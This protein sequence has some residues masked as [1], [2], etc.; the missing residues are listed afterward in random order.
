MLLPSCRSW[1]SSWTQWCACRGLKAGRIRSR[2]PHSQGEDG[3]KHEGYLVLG[4]DAT[5][6]LGQLLL[7]APLDLAHECLDMLAHKRDIFQVQVQV[8]ELQLRTSPRHS[9]A[10]VAVLALQ[11]P[12]IVFNTNDNQ[13]E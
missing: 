9:V 8:G 3:A 6:G 11:Q 12:D 13:H 7:H 10:S 2:T 4:L 1:T 5:R